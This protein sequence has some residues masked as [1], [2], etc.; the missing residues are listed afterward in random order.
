MALTQIT[1]TGIGSVD[2]LTPTTIF[3][4][5]SGSANALDDYE[6]GSHNVTD[7]SGAGLSITTNRSFY[8]KIGSIVNYQA[9][10]VFPS[11]SNGSSVQL[12]L[13]FSSNIGGYFAGTG[14]MGY[15]TVSSSSYPD[16]SPMVNNNGSDIIFYYGNGSAFTNA[17][18]SGQRIDFWVQWQRT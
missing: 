18:A 17:A 13:P 16:L 3:L 1:G 9:S 7:L 8:V 12:S 14:V 11:T 6:E 10:I 4:G 5:G 2:S 15:S